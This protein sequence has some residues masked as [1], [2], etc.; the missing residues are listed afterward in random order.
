[1]SQK[2]CYLG[3]F[4]FGFIRN[5]KQQSRMLGDAMCKASG[6]LKMQQQLTLIVGKFL[7]FGTH[8]FV[9][10]YWIVGADRHAQNLWLVLAFPQEPGLLSVPGRFTFR[11][12]R[13]Y[14]GECHPALLTESSFLMC[15]LTTPGTIRGM[16]TLGQ[17]LNFL[18]RAKWGPKN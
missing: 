2:V 10:A 4:I 3:R 8:T 1:M 18:N 6:S 16:M 9:E 11:F 5:P 15:V 14:Y 12:R 13:G 7:K 17:R